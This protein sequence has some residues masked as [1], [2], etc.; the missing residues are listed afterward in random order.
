MDYIYVVGNVAVQFL[1]VLHKMGAAFR[2]CNCGGCF[3]RENRVIPMPNGLESGMMTEEDRQHE[4]IVNELQSLG[5][6]RTKPGGSTFNIVGVAPGRR[7]PN[8]LP[9]LPAIP[10]APKDTK[11]GENIKRTII[12]WGS[13]IC[14]WN[15]I[16]FNIKTKLYL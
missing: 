13:I 9:V 15:L 2:K 8:R 3:R 5:L 14:L 16:T 4:E 7:P 1:I 12:N 6:I 11:E 10:V